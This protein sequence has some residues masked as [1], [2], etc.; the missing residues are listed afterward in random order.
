[1]NTTIKSYIP[2]AI[3][4]HIIPAKKSQWAYTDSTTASVYRQQTIDSV[5]IPSFNERW[6]GDI[7]VDD[8]MVYGDA[9]F[10]FSGYSTNYYWLRD[11]W[12]DE[13]NFGTYT[14]EPSH[15]TSYAALVSADDMDGELITDA[16]VIA[17]CFCIA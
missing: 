6:D 8:V 10:N 3:S 13:T 15:N 4:S 2:A 5:W 14:H 11:K 16:R 7:Y 17:I 9:L 12:C 1:M